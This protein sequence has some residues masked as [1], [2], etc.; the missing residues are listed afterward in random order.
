MKSYISKILLAVSLFFAFGICANAQRV[1]KRGK[2]VVVVKKKPVRIAKRKTVKVIGLKKL[3]RKAVAISHRGVKY[4]FVNNR[5]YRWNNNSYIVTQP[6]IGL[7]LNYLP[8]GHKTVIIKGRKYY[9]LNNIY[10]IKRN[11]AFEVVSIA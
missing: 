10:Y 3:P 4:H 6:V 2:K 9:T 8:L 1:V 7:R 11:N 5:F